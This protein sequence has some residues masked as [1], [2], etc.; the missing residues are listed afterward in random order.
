MET[1]GFDVVEPLSGGTAST[2]LWLKCLVVAVP[3]L[4]CFT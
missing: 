2:P 4:S 3:G 1:M